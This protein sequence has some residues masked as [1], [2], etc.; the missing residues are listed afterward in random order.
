MSVCLKVGLLLTSDNP[1]ILFIP[2]KFGSGCFTARYF[3]DNICA[4]HPRSKFKKF[5]D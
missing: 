2:S 3:G 4:L 1:L 5:N